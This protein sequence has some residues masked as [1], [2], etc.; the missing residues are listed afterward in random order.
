MRSIMACYGNKST[1]KEIER[2]FFKAA[3]IAT[4]AVAVSLAGTKHLLCAV[5]EIGKKAPEVLKGEGLSGMIGAYLCAGRLMSDDFI[6]TLAQAID[7][8]WSMLSDVRHADA[9]HRT[10]AEQRNEEEAT[11]AFGKETTCEEAIP[12]NTMTCAI[13]ENTDEQEENESFADVRLSHL[14]FIDAAEEPREY[15]ALLVRERV[16]EIK[17]VTRYRRSFLSRLIQSQGDVQ[18]YYSAVKNKLLSYKGVKGRVS[19]GNESFHKGRDYVAKINVKAKTLYLYLALPNTAVAAL[20]N[21]KYNVIDVSDKKKYENVPTL[22]K[23]KGPRKLKYALELI[24]IL[25]RDR[26]AL[27]EVKNF[28]AADYT[29]PY[30]STEALVEA[31]SIR[32]M[33][34]AILVSETPNEAIDGDVT[35]A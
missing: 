22:I 4:D 12:V 26:M 16:G 27:S 5:R 3:C 24:D 20:E 17:L 33:V 9:E 23:I 25:C 18:A 34:A 6:P 32:M 31:G 2:S 19:W 30:Q 28:E 8:T 14:H 21:G 11:S 10:V 29:V 15:E 35:L 13:E 7:R 1:R